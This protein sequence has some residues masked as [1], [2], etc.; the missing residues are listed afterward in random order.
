MSNLSVLSDNLMGT[1][2]TATLAAFTMGMGF[3]NPAV[4]EQKDKL[5]DVVVQTH[6]TYK[7]FQNSQPTTQTNPDFS[8]SEEGLI[9]SFTNE[10]ARIDSEINDF[11]GK[12]SV[13]ILP[14]YSNDLLSLAENI[15]KNNPNAIKNFL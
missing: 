7:L 14:E 1:V 11:M 5:A 8:L 6:N 13:G 15:L 9:F 10:L 3:V 12:L 4:E 2:A